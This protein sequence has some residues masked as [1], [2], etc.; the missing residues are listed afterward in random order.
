LATA[1]DSA[2]KYWKHRASEI[3]V[4]IG[5]DREGERTAVLPGSRDHLQITQNRPYKKI[6]CGEK[7]VEVKVIV[8]S[9]KVL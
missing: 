7:L 2:H 1:Q 5:A 4:V 3:V 8:S 9:N 6:I